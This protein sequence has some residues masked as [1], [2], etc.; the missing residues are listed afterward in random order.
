[1]C[2]LEAD[3]LGRQRVLVSKLNLPRLKEEQKFR[4]CDRIGNNNVM[5]IQLLLPGTKWWFATD[6]WKIFPQSFPRKE[7]Q[8]ERGMGELKAS[9][10]Y[11]S[12]LT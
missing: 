1:M 5:E 7:E 12:N 4:V 10:V 3:F 11:F 8:N 2:L 6:P 9:L